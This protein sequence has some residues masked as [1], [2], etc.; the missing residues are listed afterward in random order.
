MTLVVHEDTGEVVPNR[1]TNVFVPRRDA[2]QKLG[3]LVQG[4]MLRNSPILFE[5]NH[6]F[7]LEGTHQSCE[8]STKNE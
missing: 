2:E 7:L 8:K 6:L 1:D 5:E 4:G 3:D